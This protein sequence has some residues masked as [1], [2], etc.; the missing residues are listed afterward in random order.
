MSEIKYISI[1]I[2]FSIIGIFIFSVKVSAQEDVNSN[3][4]ESYIL[5]ERDLLTINVYDEPDLDSSQRI[6]GRGLVRIPLLGNLTLV[7]L[8]IREAEDL[9]EK[10]FQENRFLVNPQVT[11]NID[12]YSLKEVSILGQVKEP[13]RIP[14]PLEVN[15]MD[16]VEVITRAGGFTGIA[17]SAEILITRKNESGV[18]TTIPVN[19]D[20]IIKGR[21]GRAGKPEGSFI[22]Y[23]DDVIFV[24]QRVF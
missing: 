12:E 20:N 13:G 7:G 18:E 2:L 23:P 19:V 17:K 8:T 24:P 14:F 21:Q 10:S 22:V 9:I 1:S 4:K 15:T 16:I 6:D 11:I 3:I 5:T